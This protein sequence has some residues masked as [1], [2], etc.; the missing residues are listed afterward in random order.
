[1]KKIILI[2]GTRPN[3]IKAF[4]V[5]KALKN[6]FELTLIHTGQHF[7]A[8]M[9]DVFFNQLGFP[10]PDIHLSLESKS[11]A[12][13]YDDKLYI[14]NL[15]YLRDKNKVI[16]ELV[17]EEYTKLG[18]LG[19]IRHKLEI[20]FDKIKPDMVIV[21]GDVTSTL[22][23]SL[24]AHKLSIEIAHVE[25]GLRSRDLSMPEEVNRILT[26]HIST[27]YFVTE[28]SG[29]DNLNNEG[30]T[31][32]V[33][34]VGNTM[35]DCLLMFKD[36]AL[37]I[38]YHE[39][40]GIK[41]NEYILVTLHR[42]SN[43]DDL[44]KLKEI[45]DELFELSNNEKLVYPIHPR[46]K[47]NLKKIDYLEKIN[48]NAN[49]ILEEPLGYL[50]FICLLSNAK[51]V[52]T[53]SGG[54]QEE[55]TALN[56]PCF[57]LRPN[58]ERP[59]TLIKNG[60]TNQLI[61]LIDDININFIDD[62][63]KKNNLIVIPK[64]NTHDLILLTILFEINFD[65]IKSSLKYISNNLSNSSKEDILN[66]IKNHDYFNELETFYELYLYLYYLDN[67]EIII[68][69]SKLIQKTKIF[70]LKKYFWCNTL[71]PD[72]I[73]KYYESFKYV[74]TII[75]KNNEL[76][77]K[78]ILLSSDIEYFEKYFEKYFSNLQNTIFLCIDYTERDYFNQLINNY[79]NLNFV[80][81]K[82]I[83]N[84]KKNIYFQSLR[85]HGLK[86]IKKNKKIKKIFLLNIDTKIININIENIN[87]NTDMILCNYWNCITPIYQKCSMN[88]L[89]IFNNINTDIFVY[90][91]YKNLYYL[92][93]QKDNRFSDQLSLYYTISLNNN[94][95]NILFY[96]FKKNIISCLKYKKD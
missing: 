64:K 77:N 70:N 46:T 57:T 33:F 14:D 22:S 59:S 95:I 20:E 96:N 10:K 80:V 15:D 6:N 63:L 3:F 65:K 58:T 90:K 9:S 52:I 69:I 79:K 73:F 5:F 41:E 45:F 18:Q 37:K 8:K 40:I 91:W 60:G 81:F 82:N 25:S 32:N 17:N 51:Y 49:I 78:V 28:Q 29:V 44:E 43:V 84:L 68:Y 54:I 13:E 27:Y 1:M 72:N 24:A 19:E 75:N 36:K 61:K 66:F 53:D 74:E 93:I 30:K 55:T 11:R 56:V 92:L 62:N 86:I 23:A 42:P 31:E 89:V 76:T 71:L 12:G 87:K 50:E 47:A 16:S 2:V 48:L 88:I 34:L 35:I 94:K 4:P 7:D 39:K 67:Y 26:D 83:L 21:F 38:K 85:I